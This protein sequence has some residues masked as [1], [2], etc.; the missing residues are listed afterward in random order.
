MDNLNVDWSRG[1][2]LSCFFGRE[3]KIHK[4]KPWIN[5]ACKEIHTATLGMKLT[6]VVWK[7]AIEINWSKSK[8]KLHP[9]SK[10]ISTSEWVISPLFKINI[11]HHDKTSQHSKWMDNLNVDWSSGWVLSCFFGCEGKIHKPKPWIN[12]AC[13]EI[14]TATLGMKL[15][16]V[17]CKLE[18]KRN[19]SKSK[20]K[21]HR[22]S[23]SISTTKFVITPLFKI[24]IH[25]QM[26][27]GAPTP[28]QY[29]P[30]ASTWTRGLQHVNWVCRPIHHQSLTLS[31]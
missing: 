23:K 12:Q 24:N 31:S 5:Q 29:A 14:H 28:N 26:W 7:L 17:V 25:H 13:K 8:V 6:S 1:W 10:S 15:T 11:H 16:S 22:Y 2:I 4:P 9:Y 18:I 20:V 30:P 21:L 27:N 19:L 3:G